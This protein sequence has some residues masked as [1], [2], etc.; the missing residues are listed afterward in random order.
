MNAPLLA[1]AAALTILGTASAQAPNAPPKNSAKGTTIIANSGNGI[2]NT[3]VIEGSGD[4][5][6]VN[7]RNGIGNNVLVRNGTV[8]DLNTLKYRG[9]DNKFWSQKKWDKALGSDLYWCP[10]TALWFRYDAKAD[11]Y[12]PEVR[13]LNRE[14]DDAIDKAMKDLERELSGLPR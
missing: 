9:K 12:R 7:S 11:C 5:R 2:G 8:I 6:L 13:V 1:A 14:I 3:I 4:V 10:K